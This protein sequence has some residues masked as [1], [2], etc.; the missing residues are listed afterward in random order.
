MLWPLILIVPVLIYVGVSDLRAMR[1]PN[2][3]SLLCVAVFVACLPFL[4]FEEAAF[5][6]AAAAAVFGLG[7]VLFVARIV[8]GGDVKILAALMLFIPTGT[9]TLFGLILSLSLLAT[10]MA[11]V[12]LRASP[13]AAGSRWTG[14]R[15]EA[16]L[17]MGV[18]IGL[19]GVA[20]LLFL[21]AL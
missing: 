6:V 12:A 3:A 10:V 5:R 13:M 11:L 4:G 17:P 21:L 15:A 9:L 14:L 16:H 2:E 19:A 7:L 20:H 1:I 8:A 18:A